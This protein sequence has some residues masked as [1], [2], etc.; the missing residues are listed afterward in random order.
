MPKKLAAAERIILL[1]NRR[2]RRIGGWNHAVVM[3]AI[4]AAQRRKRDATMRAIEDETQL[5]PPVVHRILHKLAV[6]GF[7]ET[8][9]VGKKFSRRLSV[10]GIRKL[11][12]LCRY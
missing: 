10:L 12:S 1:T 8:T 2:I 3:A 5:S 4:A 9:R 6:A 7:V 11:R